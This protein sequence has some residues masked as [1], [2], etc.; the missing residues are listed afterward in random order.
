MTRT[1]SPAG[2]WSCISA[3]DARYLPA[4]CGA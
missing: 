2:N 1:R 3:A 4:G